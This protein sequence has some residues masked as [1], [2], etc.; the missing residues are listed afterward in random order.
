MDARSDRTRR[1]G[2]PVTAGRQCTPS[3]FW[4]PAKKAPST[5]IL[6]PDAPVERSVS[7][8]LGDVLR[9]DV[10]LAFQVGD[11]PGDSQDLVMGP[12]DN[13][14]SS[15]AALRIAIASGFRRR[16]SE[17]AAASSGR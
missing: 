17:P 14:R 7:D 16:T 6:C 5:A 3:V 4:S 11:R 10:L 12:A 15:I 13:P 8:G 9:L 2:E 1:Y